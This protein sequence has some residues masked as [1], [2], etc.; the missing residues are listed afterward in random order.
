MV[1]SAVRFSELLPLLLPPLFLVIA[2]F[3][4][5]LVG[6]RRQT[7]VVRIGESLGIAELSSSSWFGF[8]TGSW[9]GYKV[10]LR[11]GGGGK[12]PDRW[13]VEIM[14][15]AP[16]VVAVRRKGFFD[17]DLFSGPRA[18][19]NNPAAEG[20]RISG[21][22]QLAAQLFDKGTIVAEL[23]NSLRSGRGKLDLNGERVRVARLFHGSRNAE[24]IGTEAW[25]LA[26]AVVEGLGLP[27]SRAAS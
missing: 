21:D 1:R 2:L 18:T 16:G 7:R 20:F 3:I 22:E 8:V 17:I 11:H 27:P 14:A 4:A 24:R 23:E 5:S 26:T 15:T 13:T 12:A 25:R 6:R 9:R 10:R 19:V